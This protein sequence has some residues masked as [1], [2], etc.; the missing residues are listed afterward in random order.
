MKKFAGQDKNMQITCQLPSQT[1]QT[2]LG[3]N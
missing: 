2:Q 1:K 3:E